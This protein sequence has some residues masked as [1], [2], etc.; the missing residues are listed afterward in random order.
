M[1]RSNKSEKF[2]F[3]NK[4]WTTRPGIESGPVRSPLTLEGE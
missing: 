4:S 2:T 1:T 3:I